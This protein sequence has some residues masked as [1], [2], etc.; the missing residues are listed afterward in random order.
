MIAHRK[1]GLAC[2][3]G[4]MGTAS[5]NFYHR[6]YGRQGWAETAAEVHQRWQAGDHAANL[7]PDE[8]VLATTRI[9]TEAMVR[10]RLRVWRDTGV[11]TV[12]LYPTD[13]KIEKLGGPSASSTRSAH[14]PSRMIPR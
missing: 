14:R 5:T 4:G 3:L 7:V 12:H 13:D 2:S 1:K 11:D 9:G 10:G 8:M 6:A